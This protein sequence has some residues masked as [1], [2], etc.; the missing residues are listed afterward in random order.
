MKE[1]PNDPQDFAKSHKYLDENTDLQNL[2][3]NTSM[4]A[5]MLP[6]GK[7]IKIPHPD[8]KDTTVPA[9][10]L[11]FGPVNHNSLSASTAYEIMNNLSGCPVDYTSGHEPRMDKGIEYVFYQSN[12]VRIMSYTSK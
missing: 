7:P 1:L 11:Q 12:E 6:L 4:I 8:K 3:I 2:Q 9:L 10:T 5:F